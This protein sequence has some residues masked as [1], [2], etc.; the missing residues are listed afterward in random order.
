MCSN[1]PDMQDIVGAN[2]GCGSVAADSTSVD[3]QE[4][5]SSICGEEL[6]EMIFYGGATISVCHNC[7]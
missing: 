5:N 7:E 6:V 2:C 1:V 4:E 3:E